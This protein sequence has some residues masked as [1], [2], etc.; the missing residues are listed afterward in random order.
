MTRST[1]VAESIVQEE[2]AKWA[3]RP[4]GNVGLELMTENNRV[5]KNNPLSFNHFFL[6]L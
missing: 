1:A 2:G 4:A 3:G 5:L 6:Q